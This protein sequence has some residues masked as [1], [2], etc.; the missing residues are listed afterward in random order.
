MDSL[1]WQTALFVALQ[2]IH[3]LVMAIAT[4]GRTGTHVRHG[5]LTTTIWTVTFFAPLFA[6]LTQLD[7][8]NPP[9]RLAVF[10]PAIGLIGG[11]VALR[12]WGLI[13]L[14]HYFS[15]LI[16]IR[17]DHKLITAGPYRYLRHPLHVGLLLQIAGFAVIAGLWW[18]WLLALFAVVNT[19]PRERTEE[20]TLRTHFGT[21]YDTYHRQTIGLTDLIPEKTASQNN[22]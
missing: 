6:A 4:R 19:I 13:H 16:V 11:G 3:K 18:V 22:P 1:P 7:Y 2:V 12:V 15:E 8:F 10:L 5:Y 14:R 17:N 9:I 21:D 20:R